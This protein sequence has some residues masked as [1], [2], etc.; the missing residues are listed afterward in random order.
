MNEIAGPITAK[1]RDYREDARAKIL[2]H[3][4]LSA[5][6]YQFLGE[7]SFPFIPEF[8]PRKKGIIMDRGGAK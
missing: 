5:Y 4:I 7:S 1:V 8:I 3:E 2:K 6:N